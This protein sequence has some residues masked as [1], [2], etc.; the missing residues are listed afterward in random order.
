M[1]SV[2]LV[3]QVTLD[4]TRLERNHSSCSSHLQPF[5]AKAHNGTMVTACK[6]D[7]DFEK[8]DILS[9]ER[10]INKPWVHVTM[11]RPRLLGGSGGQGSYCDRERKAWW[12]EILRVQSLR[13]SYTPLS[14]KDGQLSWCEISRL[15]SIGILQKSLCH[16]VVGKK[17]VFLVL[18]Q[19]SYYR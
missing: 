19:C 17:G 11:K 2:P 8:A 18:N 5:R 9:A 7:Q 3:A 15:S 16:H 4:K 10:P 13:I 12:I 14:G 6:V 1:P